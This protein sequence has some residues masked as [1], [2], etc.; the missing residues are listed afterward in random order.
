MKFTL[1]EEDWGELLK[2]TLAS[3]PRYT[4]NDFQIGDWVT[5]MSNQGWNIEGEIIKKFEKRVKVKDEQTGDMFI[6]KYT[7]LLKLDKP[8]QATRNTNKL[9][10]V[11]APNE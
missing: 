3:R 7:Q 9:M 11:L 1:V 10:R 5:F 8:T 6:P 2:S 4:A